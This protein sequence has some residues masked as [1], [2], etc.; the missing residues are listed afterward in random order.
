MGGGHPA[1]F[2]TSRVMGNLVPLLSNRLRRR[3]IA[4]R[5][6]LR[7]I[8]LLIAAYASA[9]AAP[10]AEPKR[11]LLLQSFGR[12]FSPFYEYVGRFR[13]QLVK[14]SPNPIDFYEALLQTARFRDPGDEGSFVEYLNALFDARKLDLIVTSGAPAAQFVQRNRQRLFPSTPLLIASIDQ[15]FADLTAL[16]PQDTV[17]GSSLDMSLAIENIL[18]VL[19]NTTNVAVV[20]GSS[21]LEKRWYTILQR[22]FEPYANKVN[23]IWLNEL[24]FD[25]MRRRAA[26]LPPR[27]AIFYGLLAVDSS[28]ATQE[29][30]RMLNDLHSAANAPIFGW[31]DTY[32]GRGIVGGRLLAHQAASQR[33]ATVAV[34]ILQ[35]ETPRDIWPIRSPMPSRS[36]GRRS[37][38]PASRG[39]WELAA[40]TRSSAIS[41]SRP[42]ISRGA[43]PARRCSSRTTSNRKSG[44]G[45]SRTPAAPS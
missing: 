29:Q 35:G 22:Q 15:R 39:S 12:E 26:N 21:P 5:W 18:Q 24:T 14:Q 13:E 44:G 19:P 33:A 2:T 41:S 25:E 42:S 4:S 37:T 8:A 1:A 28:G 40:S 7:A 36:I 38:G 45:I 27:S 16:S 32:L 9:I 31:T 11:V 34:R 17:V 43:S 3:G 30:N 23:F 10:A 20:L 6:L